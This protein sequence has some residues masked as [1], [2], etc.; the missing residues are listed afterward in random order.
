MTVIPE[1]RRVLQIR[2]K[3]IFITASMQ[4]FLIFEIY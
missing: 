2:V 3:P 4:A 1:M